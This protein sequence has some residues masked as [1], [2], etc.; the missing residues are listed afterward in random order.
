MHIEVLECS[1]IFHNV[2]IVAQYINFCEMCLTTSCA[3]KTKNKL[4]MFFINLKTS[5]VY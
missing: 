3:I 5:K 2:V 4:A 1:I